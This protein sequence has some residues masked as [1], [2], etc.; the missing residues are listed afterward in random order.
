MLPR[1][2]HVVFVGARMKY[3]YKNEV[4]VILLSAFLAYPI[5]RSVHHWLLSDLSFGGIVWG[6][7]VGFTWGLFSTPLYFS[8]VIPGM[9]MTLVP[10]GAQKHSRSLGLSY[11]EQRRW[12]KRE[13]CSSKFSRTPCMV[14]KAT[15]REWMNCRRWETWGMILDSKTMKGSWRGWS[16]AGPT[17]MGDDGW[18]N[19]PGIWQ[20]RNFTSCFF[21][22][23]SKIFRSA[24][25]WIRYV[26]GY[27][28]STAYASMFEKSPVCSS[29]LNPGS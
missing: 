22:S 9:F 10:C 1:S 26:S 4:Y 16:M 3:A 13:I 6:F 14:T 29:A 19:L 24:H 2:W 18:T 11:Q 23:L 15:A 7:F 27:S 8:A 28:L 5:D 12:M 21:R 17:G 25:F 20:W